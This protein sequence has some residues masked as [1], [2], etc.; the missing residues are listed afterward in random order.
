MDIQK[1][2]KSLLATGL[3]QAEIAA[4][5]DCSQPNISEIANGQVGKTRP[6]YKIVTGIQSLAKLHH[7]NDDGELILHGELRFEAQRPV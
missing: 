2:V 7:I 1:I 6:S 3:T 5:V 4:H